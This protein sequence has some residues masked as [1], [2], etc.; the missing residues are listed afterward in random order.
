M[1][2]WAITVA[3]VRRWFVVLPILI[4][5][6]VGAYFLG[7]SVEPEY[8]I[9]ATWIL[10]P[11]S[12]VTD[13]DTVVPNP[14]G[15]IS[16]AAVAVENVL[17]SP[18]IEQQV[19]ALGLATP[20]DVTTQSRTT[21]MTFSVR[22]DSPE[23]GIGTAD[24]VLEVAR[25][26]LATRQTGAG[27]RTQYQ[28][29]LAVLAPPAVVDVIDEGR[30]RVQAIVVGG[31]A[32][33]ALVMAVLVDEL[34]LRVRRRRAAAASRETAGDPTPLRD[35][36]TAVEDPEPTP[37]QVDVPDAERDAP[38]PEPGVVRRTRDPNA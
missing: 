22:S 30:L 14:Y 16:G 31:G 7:E 33:A 26:E 23:A 35:H 8:E 11:G 6:G 28:F 1:D 2:F 3:V 24:E 20:F 13:P 27:V 19:A 37:P 38:A 21:I 10:V 4:L 12:A 17:N 34:I 32:I 5:A 36:A 18:Q 9:R 25:E 15:N 29:S